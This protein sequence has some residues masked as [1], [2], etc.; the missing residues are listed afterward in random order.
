MN[1]HFALAGLLVTTML[2]GCVVAPAPSSSGNPA[3]VTPAPSGANPAPATVVPLEAA[4]SKSPTSAGSPQ[5]RPD[6]SL[7]HPQESRTFSLSD[8]LSSPATET[9]TVSDQAAYKG[10]TLSFKALPVATLFQG[11]PVAEGVSIEF[12]SLDGFSASLDPKLL[13]NTNPDGAIAYLAIEEPGHPWPKLTKG[14]TAGPLY[15]VWRNPERSKVGQEQWPYQLSSFTV[16]APIDQR[17]PAILPAEN[18]ALDHP[19]RLG[20]Q[21]FVKNCFACH[22]LNGQG[23]GRLGPDLNEPHSPTEYMHEHYLRKLVRDPQSV[24]HWKGSRMSAFPV[25]SLPE[26]ELDQI[27]AYLKH[28]AEQ[29]R[30]ASS[31]G[32]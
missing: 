1:R 23:N 30:T 21:A 7:H 12:D 27:I 4:A 8:L 2:S 17:F 6:F 18:L 5:A 10:Q 29:R 28:K 9:L 32:K 11:L 26:T 16:K 20:Y 14:G 15:L 3:S 24:R 13:L 31:K 22:T 19:A 25:D